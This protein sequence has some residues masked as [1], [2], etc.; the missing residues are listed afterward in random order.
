M[1][2]QHERALVDIWIRCLREAVEALTGE[3]PEITVPAHSGAPAEAVRWWRQ[4]LDH[5]EGA[6]IWVGAPEATA[7]SLGGRVL[8]AAGLADADAGQARGTYFE[9]LQQATSATA[10]ALGGRFGRE[11]RAL[12][13]EEVSGQAPPESWELRLALPGEEPSSLWVAFEGLG[14]LVSPP[15]EEATLVVTGTSSSG[16][17][18]ID[19][20][21]DVE[22]PVSVSFGRTQLPLKEVLKLTSGSIVELNR[23]VAEPVEVIVNNCVIARGEVVVVEGNYGVRITEIVSRQQRLRT[24][25]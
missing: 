23:P 19:L 12:E 15:V 24:L 3:P 8:Q 13:S 25:G 17:Q 10:V 7:A 6:W 20:L 21:L 22:L 16:G 14:E 9:I 11:L 5:P 1:P 2:Q 4:R 18:P